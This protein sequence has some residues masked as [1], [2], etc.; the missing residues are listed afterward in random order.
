MILLDMKSDVCNLRAE[1]E[2]ILASFARHLIEIAAVA[3]ARGTGTS[4]TA[5][6]NAMRLPAIA[7][8][9]DGF[10]AEVNAA[11]DA[12]FDD[13]IRIKDRRI[14]FRDPQ[15]RALLSKATEQ[16]RASPSL[17]RLANEPI[18]VQR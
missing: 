16:L 1:E 10:V 4:P 11:A 8:D 17:S 9:Q 3:I 7:I 14:F 6:L 2:P 5:A 15:A 12:I 13:D 18:I